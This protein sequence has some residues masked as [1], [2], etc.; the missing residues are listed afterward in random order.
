MMVF[1]IE[2]CE[3]GS[4]FKGLL[5]DNVDVFA[6]T[7][8]NATTS[9]YACYFDKERKTFL[10]DVYSIKW[11]EDSDKENI[12]YETLEDQYKIV[13]RETNTSEGMQFGDMDIS[14]MTVGTFQGSK[15]KINL[16]RPTLPPNP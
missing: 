1:Y 7:A 4:M 8:S 6:T 5:P 2:A 13:K 12:E 14:K 3:S 15:P 9:S 11:L 16:P 10:G